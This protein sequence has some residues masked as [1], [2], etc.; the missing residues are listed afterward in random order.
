MTHLVGKRFHE[1]GVQKIT[2]ICPQSSVLCCV[3]KK[4][5]ET[6]AETGTF[7]NGH[8]ASTSPTH[9]IAT[10]LKYENGTKEGRFNARESA[11]L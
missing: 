3:E 10:I 9:F 11:K 7:F 8:I 1:K 2:C 4:K 5:L 6:G